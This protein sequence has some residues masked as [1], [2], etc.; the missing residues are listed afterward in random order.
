MGPKSGSISVDPSGSNEAPIVYKTHNP[1]KDEFIIW[2]K[3]GSGYEAFETENIRVL[4]YT[5]ETAPYFPRFAEQGQV[6]SLT[7]KQYS[8]IKAK[9]YNRDAPGKK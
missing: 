4:P 3:G 7:K 8:A 6:F 9:Y 1:H 5:R 2:I